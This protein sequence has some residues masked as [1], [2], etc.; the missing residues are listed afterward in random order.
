MYKLDLTLNNLQ[1][2]MCHK[3]ISTTRTKTSEPNKIV[4]A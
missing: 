4:F 1:W 3:T 2:L